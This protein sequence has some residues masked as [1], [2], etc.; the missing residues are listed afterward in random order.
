MLTAARGII[1]EYISFENWNKSI[2]F[3]DTTSALVLYSAHRD[4]IVLL[5]LFYKQVLL[6][7][8]IISRPK[9]W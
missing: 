1:S 9:I 2:F 5:L 4:L 7:R 3:E 8:F 6:E